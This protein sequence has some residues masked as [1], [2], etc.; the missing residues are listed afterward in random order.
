MNKKRTNFLLEILSFLLHKKQ[1]RS[2]PTMSFSLINNPGKP[3]LTIQDD[4]VKGLF[5][6]LKNLFHI[7]TETILG[8]TLP[9]TLTVRESKSKSRRLSA[10]M[11]ST[12]T[13]SISFTIS[14]REI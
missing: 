4:V 13:R 5:S 11:R 6:L 3:M 10:C 7:Q 2:L 1:D 12:D 8:S 14:L 9:R